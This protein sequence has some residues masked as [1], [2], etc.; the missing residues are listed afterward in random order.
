MIDVIRYEELTFPEVAHLPRDVPML[1][2]LGEADGYDWDAVADRV[3][4]RT[5][6]KV[7][8]VCVFPGMPFG[9]RTRQPALKRLAVGPALLRPVLESLI[10]SV[11][12]DGFTR[13]FVINGQGAQGFAARDVPMIAAKWSDGVGSLPSSGML[14]WGSTQEN[15]ARVALIATG[16][17]EQHAFHLPLNTDTLIIGAIAEGVERTLSPALSEVEGPANV[18]RLPTWP[19]GVSM[20]R[21]QYPGTLTI[22][23]R[24]WEDFWVAIVGNLRSLGF[25]MA[26]LMNGHGGNHSFLVNI[27]KFCGDR[28]PDTFVATAFLHTSSGPGAEALTK[29]RTSKIGGMGHAC[30]LETSYIL[31]LRP[32]LVRMDRAA[33]EIDFTATPNY[34]M[35]WIESGALIANPPWTDDTISGAYG[36]ATDGTAE[37]G[38]AWL[39]AAIEE[40]VGHVR[41]IVEQHQRR[42]ERREEGWVTGSWWKHPKLQRMRDEG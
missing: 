36:A 17:T 35:D 4:A 15:A 22:E 29:L 39:E 11:K 21:R 8:R 33:D 6:R 18:F 28:W 20:H 41:E 26:Y 7:D 13:V 30:E 37:K 12:E 32:D 2:P 25:R 42:T 14:K 34:Y 3:R 40:K 5:R 23:P 19:Y 16:H 10:A 1:I 9:F 24:A 38:L 27:T 31:H